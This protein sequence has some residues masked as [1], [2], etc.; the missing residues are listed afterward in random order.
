LR[1]EKEK[2]ARVLANISDGVL[3][4]DRQGKL[5]HVNPGLSLMLELRSE[6]PE[7]KDYWEV[8]PYQEI[9]IAIKEA[10]E[11]HEVMRREIDITVFNQPRYFSLMITPLSFQEGV[12]D[13]VVVSLHDITPMKRL[14]QRQ[15]EFITNVSHEFKTPL[16]SIKG[17]L[18]TI[19]EMLKEDPDGALK[20]LTT[21]ERQAQHLDN[22]VQDLLALTSFVEHKH[23]LQIRPLKISVL[24]ERVIKVCEPLAIKKSIRLY[25]HPINTDESVLVDATR[26]EQLFVNLVENAIKFT[27]T[28]GEVSLEVE[29]DEGFIRVDVADTGV[30]I[31]TEH[32]PMLFERFYRANRARTRDESSGSGLGLAIVKEIIQSH[33]GRV[34]V[35][36][37][38]GQGSV[39]SVY[40]HY[41]R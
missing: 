32:L 19:K 30:G 37:I 39:F 38:L 40:L 6:K 3:V 14:Q 9:N 21:V 31:A 25:L 16:S 15:A 34:E 7:D 12:L 36:S 17:Y 28:H 24:L 1:Q 22:M 23:Q 33:Q 26:I 8:V 10:L 20:F 5:V 27:P 41:Q 4:V 35:K 13:G 18:E 29:R 2:L 11:H